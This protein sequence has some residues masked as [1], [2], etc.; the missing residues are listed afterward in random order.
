M[1][2]QQ[3]IPGRIADELSRRVLREEFAP[4]SRLPSVRKLAAG[5]GVNVSTSERVLLVVQERGLAVAKDCEGIEVQDPAVTG[6]TALSPFLRESE[7]TMDRAVE[8]VFDALVARRL[9]AVSVL[10]LLAEQAAET[11][12][13]TVENAV[14]TFAKVVD[15]S[16]SDLVELSRT[17]TGIIRAL[18]LTTNR[19]AILAIF[20]DITVMLATNASALAAIYANPDLTLAAWRALVQKAQTGDIRPYAHMAEAVLEGMAVNIVTA[21]RMNH[22]ATTEKN[23]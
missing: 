19:P 5:Y 3:T 4:G 21:F 8:L 7:G 6:G 17:E 11:Y 14:E 22:Q 1:N 18:L 2:S 9:L 10:G 16:P 20:N 15:H 23:A 13:S 12:L